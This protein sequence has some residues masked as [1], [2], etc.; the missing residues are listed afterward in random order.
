VTQTVETSRST[1]E[2][3]EIWFQALTT[4]DVDTAMSVLDDDVEFVNY[5]PVPGYNTD[6]RWIGTHRGPRAVLESIKVFLD[7]CEVRQEEVLR[8]VV[9]GEEA[10]GVIHEISVVRDT[11]RDFEI[12]FI[13]H[14]TVRHGRIVRW[15]SYTDPSQIIRAIREGRS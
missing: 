9:D 14:L 11:G 15:K 1:R 7:M 2:V 6:M 10:M 8:L 12:E 3:A 4:G 5:T 13:Q